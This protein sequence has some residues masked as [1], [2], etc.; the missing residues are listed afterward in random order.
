[1]TGFNL[2]TYLNRV[3]FSGVASPTLETLQQLHLRHALTIP[4]ENLNPLLGWAVQ[5][6]P[7]SLERNWSTKAVADIVTSRIC[8]SNTRWNRSDSKSQGLQRASSGTCR[9]IRFCRGLTC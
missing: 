6:D 3:G 9:P 5:L 1:M 7:A 4:F 2:K 8:F